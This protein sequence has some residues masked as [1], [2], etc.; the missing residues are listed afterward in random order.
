ML[1]PLKKNPASCK[2]L[3]RY[4]NSANVK[5]YVR[6]YFFFWHILI[7]TKYSWSKCYSS[8]TICPTEGRNAV[9]GLHLAVWCCRARFN[10]V[11]CFALT[12]MCRLVVCCCQ[13]MCLRANVTAQNVLTVDWE[14]SW[15]RIFNRNRRIWIG[16]WNSESQLVFRYKELT[17]W[18]IEMSLNP[19]KTRCTFCWR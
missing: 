17:V 7:T 12:L 10:C 18:P 14:H 1:Q 8:L 16:N 5:S 6:S 19:H 11:T 9:Q 15:H 3:L 2:Y 4:V 13:S